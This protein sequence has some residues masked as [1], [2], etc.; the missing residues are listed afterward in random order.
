VRER[1]EGRAGTASHICIADV[2]SLP[3]EGSKLPGTHAG[4]Q[5]CRESLPLR[6]RNAQRRRSR[7]DDSTAPPAAVCR[8][9]SLRPRPQ[10]AEAAAVSQSTWP[11]PAPASS[12]GTR[13]TR[14]P[15]SHA[16]AP[17]VAAAS[18]SRLLASLRHFALHRKWHIQASAG[19]PTIAGRRW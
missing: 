5:R 17:L 4:V 13:G 19:A 15:D 14:G 6:G 1:E 16:A 12:P 2:P 8:G 9:A 3:H 10:S 7:R 18:V 11:W